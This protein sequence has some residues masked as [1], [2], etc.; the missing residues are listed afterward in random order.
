VAG[1]HVQRLAIRVTTACLIVALS[2]PASAQYFGRNKVRYRA[3]DFQVLETEHFDIYFYP[4]E[5]AGI[6]LAA[7]IAERWYA[8][9]EHLF[10]H[11]LSG[12]QPLILYATHADFE[13]TNVIAEPLSEGTG[14]VTEP[15]RRRIVLPLAGSLADTEHVIAHELV[16]AFQFDLTGEFNSHTAAPSLA[17]L[18]LWFVEGMAEY[19]SLG[20]ADGNTA[21]K[22]RDAMQRDRLPSIR[23][24]DNPSYFPYQWGHA[25]LAYIGGRYGDDAIPRLLRTG[26]ANRSLKPA[27][28]AVL[29]VTEDELSTDWH[30]AIRAAYAPALAAATR[31]TDG[32]R[33][34]IQPHGLGADLNVGPALSPDG[35][36]IAF[37]SS[38]SLFSV[39]LYLADAATGRITRKLTHTATD[40]HFSSI[41]FIHSA[42]AWDPASERIAL[43]TVVGNRP[44]LAIFNVRS[45]K[46]ERE[47]V[48]A[49]VDE[50]LNP[51]WSPDGHAIAFT[52][53]HRGLT[54]LYV[55][56]LRT[57][58]LAPI[59]DDAFADIHPVWAPDSR[60]IAFASDRF[61]TDLDSLRIGPLRLAIVDTEDRTVTA[62]PAFATG[63]HINPQW[64]PDG[65]GLYFIGDPD[66]V[67]N[68]YRV[69]LATGG[70]EQLTTM[71]TG[72]TGI[73]PSSPALSV[74]SAAGRV[75]IG[76]F[77]D[78][79]YGIYSRH[80]EG[81]AE[82]VVRLAENISV[83]PPLDK[84]TQLTSRPSAPSEATAAQEYPAKPSARSGGRDRADRR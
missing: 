45:G 6:D 29:G 38:R 9:L 52:G 17:H 30:A 83:L 7:R 59:T 36:W 5:R 51:A 26:A 12:R 69:T 62:V 16:H 31:V 10:R 46:R 57:S 22:L 63:K 4:S 81:V 2:S 67:S 53:I 15:L 61:S 64:S 72:V 73:T 32:Y 42:G 35:R 78:D 24:L 66:G 1:V 68:V 76:V 50:I 18:P 20:P 65:E 28:S 8:R 74:A 48:V 54:D 84:N 49:G 39:D 25:V 23:D 80:P 33:P 40:P 14:G 56:D 82:P 58:T 70:V 44:A 11:T 27:F 43:A 41:E 34:L 71:A 60:R 13:Q 77:D 37:L 21:M 3:F 79:R 55:Y 19:L 75:A 47:I